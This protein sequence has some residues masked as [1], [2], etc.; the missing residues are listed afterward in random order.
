VTV[1][2]MKLQLSDMLQTS[3]KENWVFG[4]QILPL[5]FP[6]IGGLSAPKYIFEDH[7][8]A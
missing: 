2:G 8:P 6:E 4:I 1:G 5:N 3:D 7:F